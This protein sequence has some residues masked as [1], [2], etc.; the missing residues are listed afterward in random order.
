MKALIT[1]LNY[2]QRKLKAIKGQNNPSGNFNYRT[3][4]QILEAAK[5]HLGTEAVILMTDKVEAFDGRLFVV[6]TAAITDGGDS[7]SATG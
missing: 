1:R 3:V 2:V 4:D 7:L 5:P 6:A